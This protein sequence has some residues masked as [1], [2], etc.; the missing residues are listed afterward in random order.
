M[1]AVERDRRRTRLRDGA[2]WIVLQALTI[3]TDVIP[4]R[5]RFGH[6]R[7]AMDVLRLPG[8]LPCVPRDGAAAEIAAGAEAAR[9]DASA[10]PRDADLRRLAVSDTTC[11][12]VAGA[13]D[14]GGVETVVAALAL[15][16][17]AHGI[18]VEVVCTAGGRCAD[19][20]RAQ[21]ARVSLVPNE[22]LAE[23]VRRSNPDVIQVHRLEPDLLAALA[24]YAR[25]SVMV[26]HA[27][28]AYLS[29]RVWLALTEF[30]A[31]AGPSIAVSAAVRDFFI[32]RLGSR[33]VHV[34]VNGVPGTTSRLRPS[35]VA[36]REKVSAAVGS[37]IADD[38]V[39]VLGLQRYSDQKNAAGL[40]DA[41]LLAAQADPRLRLI[42]AGAPES[43]L[44]VRRADAVRRWHPLGHR[45]HL[46][47]DS[48]PDA[49]L[50]GADLF[51]LDSFAEGGP[52]VAL[53]AVAMGVPVVLSD[54]G[55]AAQLIAADARM[56][57]VVPRAS[58]DVSHWAVARERRR[59]HQSN[60]TIFAEALNRQAER[61]S[62]PR[63]ALPEAF[64]LETMLSAHARVLREVASHGAPDAQA[65][66]P[67]TP[68]A[69]GRAVRRLSG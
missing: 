23:H 61:S 46:L 19:E 17:P 33:D 12:I 68:A 3:I 5:Y 18:E 10:A 47:A 21:G 29:R 28:E 54:V 38:D 31:D 15:G 57:E 53:E 32:A 27:M 7:R 45:V 65:T 49:L 44:E 41:F 9:S 43:W 8:G 39:L 69:R 20:I 11:M 64:A 2:P 50:A 1:C 42:I 62:R 30:T 52:M 63:A 48:D 6:W 26:F 60:R 16:L 67:E 35:R 25:R 14:S 22:M 37:R 56:G 55:F 24:P 34:V 40:V 4:P 59:W 51:A 66:E 58:R 36:A 13:L